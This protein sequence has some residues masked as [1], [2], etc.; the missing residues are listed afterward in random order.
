MSTHPKTGLHYI[1]T[2]RVGPA[3]RDAIRLYTK[4]AEQHDWLECI[5][6]PELLERMEEIAADERNFVV[7]WGVWAPRPPADRKAIFTRVFSEALNTEA[8]PMIRAHRDWL[9]A[10]QRGLRHVDAAFGHTPWMAEQLAR[11]AGRGFVL[12]MGWD[13]DIFGSPK[14]DSPKHYRLSYVGVLAG[15]RSWLVPMMAEQL[16]DH[17]FNATGCWGNRIIEVF[18]QSRANLYVSH[19]DIQ[20]FSTFRIWQTVASSAALIAESGRDCWPMTEE[21]YI[22]L[23]MLTK[24]NARVVCEGLKY[25]PDEDFIAKSRALHEGLAHFTIEHIVNQYLIPASIDLKDQS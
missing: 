25:I 18:N 23:P 24:E 22:G 15:K 19:S 14:W 16:G 10:A 1:I 13:P 11:H 2:F 12:P 5:P 7:M 20:S 17:F 4:I 9:V 3:Y 8:R 21:M 6:E